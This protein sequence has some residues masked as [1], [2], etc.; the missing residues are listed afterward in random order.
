MFI[1][2]LTYRSS[3]ENV[4][5]LIPQHNI[6]LN[7][8]YESGRFIASGR[9]EPRTGGIIIANAESKNEVEQIIFEDPFYIHQVADYDITEFIP[10]KYHENFKLF[11][12]D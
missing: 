12:E 2:S 9:K 10:S 3:L 11:I 1:I 6:F 4:E 7:K 5:R 8:H